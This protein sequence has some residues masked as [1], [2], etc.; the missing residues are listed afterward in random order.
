MLLSVTALAVGL[1]VSLPLGVVAARRPRLGEWALAFAGVVQ[2]IPSLALLALMV[3]LLAGRVG[4]L[5]A[6]VALTLYSVLPILANTVLGIKGIEPRL[7]EAARGL[8]MSERQMLFRVELPLA[9]PVII[10]GIRTAT[11]LVVGT[12]TLATEVGET[13]LGNYIFQGLNTRDHSA[14]VFGCVCAALLAVSLD[15]LIRLL[16]AAA[17]LRGRGRALAG[18]RAAGQGGQQ[19]Q[20]AERRRQGRTDGS[21]HCPTGH[22]SSFR[23]HRKT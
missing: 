22:A 14:T 4:F 12:A 17:R 13:T 9:A 23:L 10:A 7:T 20:G 2:T 3:L 5:P 18:G 6:F 19:H 11:V 15:Q 8:G 1:V 16:E 21:P